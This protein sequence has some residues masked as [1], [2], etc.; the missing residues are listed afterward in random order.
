M[1]VT[2]S[3]LSFAL[4]S[5]F[6]GCRLTAYKD[7]GGVWTIGIGHTS[8]FGQVYEGMCISQQDAQL[9][10]ASDQAP[11]IKLVDGIPLLEAAALVSFGFNC[12][13]HALELVLAGH[14]TIGNPKHT[15]DRHGTVLAGLVSRRRLEECLVALSQQA[16]NK[17]DPVRPI[18]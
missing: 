5:V 8:A 1:T 14:D 9:L 18:S 13:K 7:S 4:I 11:L 17:R 16:E 6:E 12:G 15:T 2:I 3:E 10:F